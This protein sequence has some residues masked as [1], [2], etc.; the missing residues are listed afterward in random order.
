VLEGLT[1]RNG[2]LEAVLE[3]ERGAV[4]ELREAGGSR[5]LVEAGTGLNAYLYMTGSDAAHAAPGGKARI[6]PLDQ[7]PLVA[8]LR[9]EAQAPGCRALSQTATL[10][11]GATYLELTT[12]VDKLRP[13]A[14]LKGAYLADASK[15]SVSLAFPFALP[16]GE[17][18]LDLPLARPIRPDIDQI[19][20]ACKNW[21]A[22]GNWADVSKPGAGV[23]LV[24][25]DTPL[26]QVGGLT[27]N[28]LNAQSDPSAW[29]T[30]HAEA[31]ALYPWLMNNH[32]HTNSRAYQ[33]GP[34]T[35]RFAVAPHGA[36]DALT[37]AHL[38]TGL[39]QPFLVLPAGGP[40]PDGTPLVRVT[41]AEVTVEVIKPVD[42]GRGWI[43]RLH[44]LSGRSVEAR[45][46]WGQNGPRSLWTSGTGEGKGTMLKGP[47]P[48]A[49][50]GV[51]TV[52][53]E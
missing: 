45:L 21:F 19:P 1:L 28:L 51:V 52:R 30:A 16:G 39:A 29:R 10:E 50:W 44:N 2:R 41:P 40:E 15:E 4:K 43:L 46:D 3:P 18:H 42:D 5:N 36:Y 37:S 14:D 33:E 47:V 49:G 6:T 24:S 23:T 27:A 11:T 25:L 13:P 20:G 22:I 53:A 12:R 35:F 26:L 8:S 7:G 17:V 31:S 48:L 32:W 9:M 38:G 34:V